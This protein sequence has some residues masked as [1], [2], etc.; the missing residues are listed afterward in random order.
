MPE[1]KIIDMVLSEKEKAICLISNAIASYSL[2]TEKG[3][4][5]DN[6]SLI[7]FIVKVIP[8]ELKSEI[9][10]ELI[11]EVFEYISKSRMDDS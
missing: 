5:P 11:D 1:F 7:D 3:S 6:I 4:L 9:S 2:Y 10:I 8:N